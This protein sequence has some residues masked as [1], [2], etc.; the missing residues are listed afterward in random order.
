MN[1]IKEAW[2]G[3]STSNISDALDRYGISGQC[4]RIKPLSNSFKL[5]GP[6][7]TIRMIPVTE[8]K[9][10]VGD[11]IDDVP[12]DS[13][14][15][16]DSDGTLDATVWGDLLTTVAKKRNIGGTVING[17][18]RDSSKSR[19]VDYPIFSLGNIM[20]T[21]KG[22]LQVDEYNVPVLVEKTR[23]V[24]GD[25]VIGDADGIV[26]VPKEHTEEVLQAA[27]EIKKKEDLIEKAVMGGIRL[28]KAR[29]KYGYFNLQSSEK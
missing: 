15:V 9:G 4:L 7:F 12:P 23:V 20:R 18:C 13:V 14:V 24:P 19:E 22:R 28:D 6:A 21:G 25:L 5:F 3:L 26:I 1:S 29:E 17:V 10:T 16:I 11:Y 27:N 2:S 8:Q